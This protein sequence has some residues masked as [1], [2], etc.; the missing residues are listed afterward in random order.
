MRWST[1]LR[2]SIISIRCSQAD[3]PSSSLRCRNGTRQTR[4]FAKERFP[5]A[6]LAVDC[7]CNAKHSR[8]VEFVDQFAPAKHVG[9]KP[10]E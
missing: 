7:S 6:G 10:P 5:E 2:T 9:D 1:S 4:S 8:E 3:S